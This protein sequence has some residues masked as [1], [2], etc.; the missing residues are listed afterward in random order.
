MKP[1]FPHPDAE[2]EFL[3][4]VDY[5]DRQRDELGDQFRIEVLTNALHVRLC[6]ATAAAG[7][8]NAHE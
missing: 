5:Y 4:G 7:P 6:D 2:A 8:S 1:M 3:A